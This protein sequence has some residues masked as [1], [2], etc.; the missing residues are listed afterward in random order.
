MRFVN[1]V[2]TTVLLASLMGL[3]MLIGYLFLG[4]H[5]LLI[6]LL[7]GGLGNVLAFFYSDKIALAA[8]GGREIQ[9][10]DA[11]QLFELVERLCER[12][13]LPMPRIYICPQA[14][15]NAFAT[16]RSPSHAALAVTQGLLRGLSRPET[17]G[18]IAHELGH[19]KHRDM[20][21]ST[22]A[23]VM[24]GVISY[25][26][27]MLMLFGGGNRRDNPLGLIGTL[28]MVILAPIAALLIQMAI[29]RQRE[30]AADSFGGE[31]CGDPLKLASALQRLQ[32]ANEHIPTQTPPAFHGLYIVQPLTGGGMASLFATHP[33]IEKRIAALRAQASR[34]R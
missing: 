32:H 6:G 23:A 11:P 26:G 34:N 4:P 28:A 19:V 20:L 24:A 17:E 21:I 2:K 18:V 30:Y 22:L 5:G 29:S 12:A 15:P 7:F 9:R 14:A 13:G 8:M 16:G 3:C 10:Q 27:W 33:P 1:S 31:L 25:A